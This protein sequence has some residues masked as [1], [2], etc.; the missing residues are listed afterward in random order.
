MQIAVRIT[1]EAVRTSSRITV[2]KYLKRFF[3]IPIAFSIITL[4]EDIYALKIVLAKG[5][6]APLGFT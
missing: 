5:S 3:N 6:Y 2:N 4:V 1:A